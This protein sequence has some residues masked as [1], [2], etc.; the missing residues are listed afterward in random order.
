LPSAK[1][2]LTW[3]H[4]ALID[5]ERLRRFH[6]PADPGAAKRAAQA[7]LEA[8]R[9]LRAFPQKGKLVPGVPDVRE[10]VVA[11]GA[12]AYCLRDLFAN[13]AVT[14]IQVKHSREER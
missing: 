7:I 13:G 5:L 1:A 6:L 9:G 14:I 2:K 12:A 3:S 11:F 8:A 4:E 10:W